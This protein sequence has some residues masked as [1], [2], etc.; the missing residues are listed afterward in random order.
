MGIEMGLCGL[1]FQ[2]QYKHPVQISLC[3]CVRISLNHTGG[4]EIVGSR[5]MH[6]SYF[7]TNGQLASSAVQFY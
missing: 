1:L 4:G 2:M 6:V 3:T 7:N 5:G